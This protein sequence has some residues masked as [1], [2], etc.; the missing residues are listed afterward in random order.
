MQVLG[1]ERI[2]KCKISVNSKKG[3][4]FVLYIPPN[5]EYNLF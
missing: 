1:V 2:C 4:V 5:L 3:G